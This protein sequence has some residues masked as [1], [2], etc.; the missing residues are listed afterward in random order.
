MNRRV[1]VERSKRASRAESL[2][3]PCEKALHE[4]STRQPSQRNHGVQQD[5]ARCT[6]SPYPGMGRGPFNLISDSLCRGGDRM[7]GNLH[8]ARD[9]VHAANGQRV[10]VS[11]PTR[12][13][14]LARSAYSPKPAAEEQSFTEK[15]CGVGR[16]ICNQLL[17]R[18]YQFTL[19]WR[20][21]MS[22]HRS[23]LQP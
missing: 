17:P 9:W 3:G 18:Y 20:T 15:G 10:D 22:C 19:L 6:R 16:R 2:A 21:H 11:T 4:L 7:G 23:S 13:S 14:P 8:D 5:G 12:F 1:W